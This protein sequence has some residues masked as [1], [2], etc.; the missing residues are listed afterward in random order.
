[1]EKAKY[2]CAACG[3]PTK[4]K[5]GKIN[6]KNFGVCHSCFDTELLNSMICFTDRMNVFEVIKYSK[7]EC[8]S[9]GKNLESKEVSYNEHLVLDK[10]VKLCTDCEMELGKFILKKYNDIINHGGYNMV[11][12]ENGESTLVFADH[13]EVPEYHLQSGIEYVLK[14]DMKGTASLMEETRKIGVNTP[15][16]IKEYIDKYVVGQERAKKVISVAIYNHYK[17]I[18]HK[19]YDIQKSNILM[20]GPTGVGKT[21]IART[22]A[23]LMQVPF[24]ICDATSVTE[25]GYVGDDVE[26][27]LLRL[28]QAADMDVEAAEHGIIYIDEIDKI[29][30][31]S[32]STSITRDVSGEGVQQALLKIIEGAE[33]DVPLTGGRKHP[34]GDRVRINTENILFICGGAFEGLTMKKEKKGKIGIFASDEKENIEENKPVTAKDIEKQGIIP[35]LIGRL[36]VIVELSKLTKDDLRRILVE[37]ENSI[38][39]QYKDLVGL[40]NVELEFTS[41]AIDLIASRAFENET[42]ARGLKSIIE[43]FM[44][45]LM[46]E[47]PDDKNIEK[48]VIDA[49][50]T[51]LVYKSIKKAA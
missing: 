19:R 38:V 37:P 25:A 46:F 29:A 15:K 26:N 12:G 28:L 16:E 41:E 31:K 45:D 7:N 10:V 27:M 20:I 1:M 40:D 14:E 50:G 22:V 35:E 23:K 8:V 17:R 3:S 5:Y 43:Q 51:E 36:P 33:V 42:G 30:R 2:V 18:E 13:T 49:N 4:I 44:T 6:K 21:E 11:L 9:C 47:L 32:E 39:K 34:H 48:V 24:V